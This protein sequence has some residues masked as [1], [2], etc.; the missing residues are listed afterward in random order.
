ME[1]ADVVVENHGSIF[2]FLPM[3]EAA[4]DWIRDNIQPDAQWFGSALCVEA[5][6]AVDLAA[7]M[8]NDGLKL[9]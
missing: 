9:K 3:T 5:R 7:G 4:Q 8:Q 6:Y 1:T 2:T